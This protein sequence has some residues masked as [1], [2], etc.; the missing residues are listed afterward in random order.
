MKAMAA[1]AIAALVFLLSFFKEKEFDGIGAACFCI[2]T[3]GGFV[4]CP[5]AMTAPHLLQKRAASPKF[6]PQF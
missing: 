6:W 5:P 4:S 1:I 3:G 2:G